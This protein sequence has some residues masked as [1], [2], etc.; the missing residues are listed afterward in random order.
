LLSNRTNS[1]NRITIKKNMEKTPIKIIFIVIV[2]A[3]ISESLLMIIL[4]ATN[5]PHNYWV[6]L[7]SLFLILLLSP[8]LYFF[9]YKPLVYQSGQ[10]IKQ[11]EKYRSLFEGSKDAIYIT[12]KEGKFIDVNFSFLDLFGYTKEEIVGTD[13][14]QIYLSPADRRLFMKEIE[15]EGSVK[16]YELQFEKKDGTTID[17]L[18]TSSLRLNDDGTVYGYQGIIRDITERKGFEEEREK[19]INELQQ[20]L[21]E[22]KTLRGIIPICA[23]CKKIR[24]DKGAWDVLEAYFAEHIDAKFTHGFCPD[25][26]KNQMEELEKIKLK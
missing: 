19:T 7:D 13:V 21:S 5:T 17:C 8:M 15:R 12:S 23:A 20:A 6:F 22:I 10:I 9:V 3:L 2:T 16:D 14:L 1:Q 18:L 26:Y 25:C 4:H 24:D 11:E